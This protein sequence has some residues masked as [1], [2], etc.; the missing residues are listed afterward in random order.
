MNLASQ[1]VPFLR[2]A[3]PRVIR[4]L[5]LA[6]VLTLA[7]AAGAVAETAP[8]LEGGAHCSQTV[9][10]AYSLKAVARGGLPVPVTCDAP[11]QCPDHLRAEPPV[12]AGP[13]AHPH[14]PPRQSR[15]LPLARRCRPGRDDRPAAGAHAVRRAVA[16]HY[17]RSRVIVHLVTLREDG[18]FWSEGPLTGTPSSR[19]RERLDDPPARM[20]RHRVR[21]ADAHRCKCGERA[22]PST[23]SGCSRAGTASRSAAAS[24]NVPVGAARGRAAR[25]VA[26][27]GARRRGDRPLQRHARRDRPRRRA[28]HRPGCPRC[29]RRDRRG[30]RRRL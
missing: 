6:V 23:A 22:Q 26:G 13:G 27:A 7:L 21:R 9:K 14:V 4:A 18:F 1:Y 5:G 8:P 10:R 24:P 28:A 15:H 19:A 12:A 25:R 11:A 30:Q 3:P 29:G 20:R 16:G 2:S 17:R